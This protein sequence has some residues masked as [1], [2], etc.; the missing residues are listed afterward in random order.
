MSYSI[1]DIGNWCSIFGF[2]ITIET[3][4]VWHNKI[5]KIINTQGYNLVFKKQHYIVSGA[6]KIN[7]SI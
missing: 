4:G 6:E 2:I 1:S 3:R 5:Y 7:N